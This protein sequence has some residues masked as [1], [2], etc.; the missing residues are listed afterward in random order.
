MSQRNIVLTD[1]LAEI[2]HETFRLDAGDGLELSGA[3]GWS[4][5][6]RTLRGGRSAGVDVIDVDNGALAVS[7][8]PTRGMGLWRGRYGDID[9]G[10][11]SPVTMP[12]HPGFVDLQDRN[13]IGWLGGFNELLCRCGLTSNGPPTDDGGTPLTLHGRIANIPAHHV[14]V[15]VSTAG[16]GTL[17][18]TGVV[19]EASLF[20]PNLRLTSTLQTEAGSN[21]V[22]I[23]DEVTNLGASPGELQLLYHINV[24]PP[25]LEEGAQFISAVQEVAPRDVRAGEGV[26][27]WNR[28]EGPT[29][30]FA[31]QVYY[32]DTIP[33]DD[34]NSTVL[35]KNSAGERGLSVEFD[36]RSL[37][38]FSLWKNTQ[39]EADGYVTGLEPGTNFPNAKPYE[40]EQGRVVSLEPGQSHTMR[41]ELAVHEGHAAVAD[42]ER[43]IVSLQ[44]GDAGI[45]HE[46]PQP[47]FSPA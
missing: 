20:G 5:S 30:G 31:E 39:P 14:D 22:T 44:A 17:S 1:A 13:G 9:L 33:D 27:S 42:R 26:D 6:Q 3:S 24:G 32:L 28:Y 2:H 38:C 8:L 43:Q 18:V 19:D 41:I 40:R 7:I 29:P 47:G 15:S 37:P 34:G 12:V 36:T 4:I 35:L 11:Q 23:I 16:N 45:F 10:W 46:S 25:L 21:C